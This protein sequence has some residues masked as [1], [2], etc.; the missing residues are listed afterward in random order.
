MNERKKLT[1]ILHGSEREELTRA[2][3]KARAADDF[4]PL[5]KAEYVAHV[6]E[7]LLD[8]SRRGK[9]E[10]RLTFRVAEGEHAGRM[11][12]HHVY[13]TT[14]A[15]PLAK[16]DLG[17]L[18]ITM[19]DQLENPLA[20]G[21]RCKARLSLRR[22]DDGTE[23]NRVERFEVVGIDTPEPDA[24]APAHAVENRVQAASVEPANGT[25]EAKEL[26]PFGANVNADGPHRERY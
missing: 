1:D 4:T 17:K 9:P 12:W 13:L 11:F 7:G 6:V 25:A 8:T 22:N 23:F 5:P 2:F 15:L 19:L 16:R 20:A 3:D 18:G 14:A 21:I 26:F 10:Y 24:F